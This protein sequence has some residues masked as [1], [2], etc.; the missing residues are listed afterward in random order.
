MRDG[1]APRLV[2]QRYGCDLRFLIAGFTARARDSLHCEGMV[3]SRVLRLLRGGELVRVAGMS[4]VRDPWLAEVIGKIGYDVI[5][6]DMEHRA[7]GYDV[8]DPISL[9][10]RRPVLT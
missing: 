2:I 6:F 5:W 3:N 8:I 1:T 9:A 7:F 4:R 10:C